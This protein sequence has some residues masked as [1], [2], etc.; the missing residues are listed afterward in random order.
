MTLVVVAARLVIAATFLL[1]G[2]GKSAVRDQTKAGLEDFG[3]PRRLV[4]PISVGLPLLELVVGGL[5][6]PARTARLGALC[7]LVLLAVF[8]VLVVRTLS[9]GRRPDCNCF[10]KLA[11]SAIGP[12]TLVRNGA[13]AVV[14]VVATGH[15]EDPWDVLTPPGHGRS[16]TSACYLLLGLAVV[17]QAWLIWRLVVQN[18]RLLR[19]VDAVRASDADARAVPPA[20]EARAARTGRVAS[21][22]VRPPRRRRHP[23]FARRPARG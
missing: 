12:R 16:A 18:R 20:G 13:L 4:A 9:R 19:Q 6:V 8:S 23:R 1:A 5:S 21:P 14:A 17:L 7:A 15:G 3:V 11:G 22:P 2:L 10:G